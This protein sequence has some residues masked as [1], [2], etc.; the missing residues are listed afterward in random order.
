[1]CRFPGCFVTANVYWH[2]VPMALY[3]SQEWL[4]EARE[5]LDG[6][7]VFVKVARGTLTATFQHYVT[8]VPAGAGG[9]DLAFWSEFQQGRCVDVRL[10]ELSSPDVTL[11]AP[12]SLWKRFHAGEVGL[13]VALL[14]LDLEVK[15]RLS[16]ALSLAPYWR[17]YW[18]NKI[19]STVPTRYN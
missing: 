17:L 10:G 16:T 12:Y 6:S 19:L 2:N 14:S 3:L 8:E 18:M 9:E 5:T 4:D 1:M 13:A 15:T 11:T 7:E